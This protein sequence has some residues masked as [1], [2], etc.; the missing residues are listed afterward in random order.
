MA[1]GSPSWADTGLSFVNTTFATQGDYGSTV[2]PY[3][4]TGVVWTVGTDVEAK[5]S[6]RA[7]HGG[8]YAYRLCPLNRSDPHHITEACFQQHPLPFA[9]KTALEFGNGVLRVVLWSAF[10]K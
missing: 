1:G 10:W 9:R 2:L 8:G 5:W 6:L 3:S 7:D 4:P